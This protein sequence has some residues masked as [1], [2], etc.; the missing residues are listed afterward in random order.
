VT[1]DIIDRIDALVDNQLQQERSGYDHNL[2][3]Q[4]CPHCG[5]D[6]HGLAITERLEQLRRQRCGDDECVEC[7][8]ALAEYRYADDETRVL[9]PGSRFI[10]P[11]PP[12]VYGATWP[13]RFGAIRGGPDPY[14]LDALTYTLDALI[15]LRETIDRVTTR[16]ARPPEPARPEVPWAIFREGGPMNPFYTAEIQFLRI[17]PLERTRDLLAEAQSFIADLNLAPPPEPETP[18]A[19]ALPRPSTTPPMW[20]P[21]MRRR[22]HR[23]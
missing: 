16:Y 6:F 12:M 18:R 15:E 11:I 20:A 2:N 5:R 1:I 8:T 17:S 13:G 19:R 23:R 22:R 9:C 10:G 3:Q 21:D 4:R 14:T 7:V